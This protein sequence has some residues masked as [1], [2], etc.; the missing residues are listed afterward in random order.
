V[1]REIIQGQT[2]VERIYLLVTI[3]ERGLSDH[4]IAEMRKLGVT[5]NMATVGYSAVGLDLVDYFGLSEHPGD[6][7]FSVVAESKKESALAMVEYKFSLDKPGKGRAFT[8]P[9][10]GVGG[11]VSLRYISGVEPEE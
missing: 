5:F 7:I 1:D 4:V 6:V 3:V 11:P 10:S 9:I 2:D 8:I